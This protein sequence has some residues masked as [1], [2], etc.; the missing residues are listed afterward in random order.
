MTVRTFDIDEDQLVARHH[1]MVRPSW[2]E[3]AEHGRS[4][5]GLR[6]T[7]LALKRPEL[8]RRQLRALLR[9]ARH[10]DL[11][12]MFPFISG[13]E[14]FRVAVLADATVELKARGESMAAVRLVM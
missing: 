12:I 10:G 8:L 4:R 7:R 5:L 13:V 9:A 6:A 14:E 1:A 11:R 3:P 2:S